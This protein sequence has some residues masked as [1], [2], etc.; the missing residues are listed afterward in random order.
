MQRRALVV[1]SDVFFVEFLAGLLERR[2]YRV[3]RAY[4][5]KQGIAGLEAGPYDVLFADLVMPKVEGRRIFEAARR[6]FNGGCFPLVAVSGTVIE[7][8][9]ELETLGADFY[10]AKGPLEKLEGRL[11]EFLDRLEKLPCPAAGGEKKILQTGGVFPRRDALELLESLEF[12]KAVFESLAAGMLVLDRDTRLLN[13][14]P[15]ALALFGRPLVE[16]LNRPVIDLFPP[17]RAAELIGLLKATARDPQGR[18]RAL[19]AEL[20]GR[21]VRVVITRLSSPRAPSGW[22]IALEGA[23]A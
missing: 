11:H 9:D 2:G 16:V 20:G 3:A 23:A 14:N 8:M 21:T 12:H 13:A 4:D 22:V 19:F 15:A 7:Q 17:A 1:D 5:G 18:A 10:I 6:R